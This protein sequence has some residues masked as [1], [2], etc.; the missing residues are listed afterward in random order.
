MP[1]A[2]APPVAAREIDEQLFRVG[3]WRALDASNQVIARVRPGSLDQALSLVG[4]GAGASFFG[5]LRPGVRVVD[6]DMVRGEG[7]AMEIVA[8]C[9]ERNLW[10]LV[11]ASGQPG[12]RHVFVV[13][14]DRQDELERFAEQL[15][16]AYGVSRPRI[17]VRDAVRPLCAPHRSGNTPPLPRLRRARR[18]LP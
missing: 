15:R 5:R 6:V 4:R 12:H 17:D 9:V 7:P 16:C 1:A 14:G 13:V 10:H 11:R 3:S 8:W 18:S 2:I